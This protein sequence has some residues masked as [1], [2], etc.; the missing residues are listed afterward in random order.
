MIYEQN[1]SGEH[2]EVFGLFPWYLNGTI[3]EPER[4]KVDEHVRIC[5]A[6]RDQ[7]ARERDIY[8]AMSAESSLEFIPASFKSPASAPRRSFSGKADAWPS[9]RRARHAGPR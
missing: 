9:P 8:R 5:A 7:L 4:Q 2:E 3:A 6:C 1:P